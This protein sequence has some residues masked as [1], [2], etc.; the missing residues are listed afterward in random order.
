MVSY[1]LLLASSALLV[2]TAAA[3]NTQFEHD[4]VTTYCWKSNASA[5][6]KTVNL[7]DMLLEGSG[8][9]CPIQLRL[10]IG[11]LDGG[12]V[13]TLE[14]MKATWTAKY[15][16]LP[17]AINMSAINTMATVKGNVVSIPHSN[18]HACEYGRT[19]CSPFDR[20]DNPMDN[21]A[22]QESNFTDSKAEFAEGDLRFPRPLVWSILAHIVV[23]GETNTTR[24]DFVVYKKLVVKDAPAPTAAPTTATPP[25]TPAP[26]PATTEKAASSTLYTIL[27]AVGALVV[28]AVAALIYFLRSKKSYGKMETE[29]NAPTFTYRPDHVPDHVGYAPSE[30]SSAAHP[31][32]VRMSNQGPSIMHDA[33]RFESERYQVP[34]QGHGRNQPGAAPMNPH[35]Y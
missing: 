18:L 2:G 26:T 14:S 11:V 23:P 21:T 6:A 19:P 16:L 17:N 1:T 10:N 20:G 28:V 24:Y 15:D 22:N 7:T 30:A 29:S 27:G 9:G 8:R 34:P 4:G 35:P 32:Y 25:P 3:F 5:M 13:P 33:Y 12:V 31:S